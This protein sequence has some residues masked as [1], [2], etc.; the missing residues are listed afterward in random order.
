MTGAAAGGLPG[1]LTSVC[2]HSEG[3]LSHPYCI[4]TVPVR[5]PVAAGVKVT[6]SEQLVPAAREAPQV[7]VWA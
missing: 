7:L 5:V 1:E 4:D 6:L 2:K 3:L